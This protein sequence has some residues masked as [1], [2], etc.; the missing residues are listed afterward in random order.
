MYVQFIE[1][2]NVTLSGDVGKCHV[3]FSEFDCIAR[4]HTRTLMD[5]TLTVNGDG[6]YKL[7]S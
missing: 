5:E 4:P 1:I 6:M 3:E 7:L 2:L